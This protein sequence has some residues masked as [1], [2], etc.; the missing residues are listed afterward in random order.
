MNRGQPAVEILVVLNKQFSPRSHHTMD[1]HA[2]S[3][4]APPDEYEFG[5]DVT[6]Q[7]SAVKMDVPSNNMFLDSTGVDEELF[8]IF[9]KASGLDTTG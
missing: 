1:P 6:P 7:P 5:F 8:D 4:G 2:T 9:Q 3:S